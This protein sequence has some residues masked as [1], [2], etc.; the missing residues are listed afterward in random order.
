ML[1]PQFMRRTEHFVNSTNVTSS[2][3]SADM[4]VEEKIGKISIW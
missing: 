1:F 3:T 2:H 4:R